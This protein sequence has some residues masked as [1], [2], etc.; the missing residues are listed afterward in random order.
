MSFTYALHVRPLRICIRI[1]SSAPIDR[2]FGGFWDS[3]NPSS[4]FYPIIQFLSHHPILGHYEL[5]KQMK[6]K[7]P[8]QPR[9]RKSL[10]W[11]SDAFGDLTL[12]AWEALM[13]GSLSISWVPAKITW[14]FALSWHDT[15]RTYSLMCP[16][17]S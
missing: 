7:H 17:P 15:P 12:R 10:L 4:N 16:F 2:S 9:Q 13:I 14:Q 11:I 6:K 8:L 5:I 1:P 3:A